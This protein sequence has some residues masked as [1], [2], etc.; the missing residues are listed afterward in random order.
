[1]NKVF[2]LC[3][4]LVV[5]IGSAFSLAN[6]QNELAHVAKIQGKYIFMCCEPAQEYEIVQ[7][8]FSTTVWSIKE[9]GDFIYPTINKADRKGWDYDALMIDVKGS[10]QLIK[11]TE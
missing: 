1:M 2:L 3:A 11:F 4:V 10:F 6:D 9:P 7:G 5:A 8:D